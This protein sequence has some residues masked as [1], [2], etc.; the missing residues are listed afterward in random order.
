MFFLEIGF[1][2]LLAPSL[3]LTKETNIFQ[4]PLVIQ[5]F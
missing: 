2:L 5:Y 4:P 3:P 1:V